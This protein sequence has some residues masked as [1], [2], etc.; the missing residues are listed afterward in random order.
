[1]NIGVPPEIEAALA[2]RAAAEGVS[3]PEY[4]VPLL[5]AFRR[6]NNERCSAKLVAKI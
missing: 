3:L 2:A 1:M 5:T 6:G 4:V